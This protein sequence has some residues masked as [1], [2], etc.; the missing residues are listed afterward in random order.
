MPD[1]GQD[2]DGPAVLVVDDDS[3]IRATLA[4]YLA[5]RGY[6][7]S[8]AGSAADAHIAIRRE[9]P[10]LVLLDLHMPG[11]DG[12]S[13]CRHLRETTDLPIVMLTG[14][15]DPTDRIVGL[16]MGAD[17]YIAKPFEL[18]QVLA[19]IRSILRR[20]DR[21]RRAPG[22]AN[23]DR[24]CRR[25]SARDGR[26]VMTVLFT[27]IVDSTR[28]A[29]AMG[30]R[31]WSMLLD[32][33]NE[34]VRAAIAANG[35]VEIKTLGDGFLAAFDTPGRAL[36]CAEEARRALTEQALPIRA[37][38]HTGE[39]EL[40]DGDIA[41]VAVHLAARVIGLAG[42]G[43]IVV[44]NTVR[45]LMTGSSARFEDRGTH[46]LKGIPG[47]WRAYALEDFGERASR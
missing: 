32:R 14:A 34:I 11:E 36:R 24:P 43:E 39:C 5:A 17:D 26:A 41:G 13:L 35:G 30:D 21:A 33:H 40:R 28:R 47:C 10:D 7:V 16:E 42:S 37:G 22:A 23:P 12:L 8:E 18:R 25:L 9:R 46:S 2:R 45:E 4:E 1:A 3:D 6:R 29:S 15:G 31:D 44:S 38:V 20:E 19:R 27:D